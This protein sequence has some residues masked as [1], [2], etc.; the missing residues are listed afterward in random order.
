[1]NHALHQYQDE[2]PAQ[3][4]F[5]LSAPEAPEPYTCQFL[6]FNTVITLQ[7]YGEYVSIKGAFEGARDLCRIYERLFSRTLPHSDISR[8][9]AAHGQKTTVDPL[10]AELVVEALKYCE[11]GLSGTIY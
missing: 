4:W 3:A 2:I 7:A 1:M 9:N 5:E 6:A 10:T 11:E 8:I